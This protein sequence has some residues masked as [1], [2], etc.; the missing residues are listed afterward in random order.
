MA[1]FKHYYRDLGNQ[2]WYIYGP[3]DASIRAG[4]DFAHLQGLKQAPIAVMIE[5]CRTGLV[6][7][8]FVANPEIE[9]KAGDLMP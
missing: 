3:R 1:A 4:L 9:V 2:L 7:K 6:W 8:N 5:N